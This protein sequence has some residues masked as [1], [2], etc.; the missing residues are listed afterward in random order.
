MQGDVPVTAAGRTA[1]YSCAH[2]V[3]VLR[4]AWSDLVIR[5]AAYFHCLCYTTYQT[6]Q[7]SAAPFSYLARIVASECVVSRPG[8]VITGSTVP[9]PVVCRLVKVSSYSRMDLMSWPEE[10]KNPVHPNRVMMQL[11]SQRLKQFMHISLASRQTGHDSLYISS[12]ISRH[13]PGPSISSL[14]EAFSGQCT[15][16]TR[17]PFG[18]SGAQWH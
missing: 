3:R 13:D 18:R 4:Q 7:P 2:S 11:V 12:T 6:S 16:L 9:T 15:S 17:T 5:A 14:G 8:R 10:F 1:Q